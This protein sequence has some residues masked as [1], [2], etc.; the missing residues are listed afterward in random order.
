MMN[1]AHHYSLPY[2]CAI[3]CSYCKGRIEARQRRLI[4]ASGID[5]LVWKMRLGMNVLSH[6]DVDLVGL[7][8]WQWVCRRQCRRPE[9]FQDNSLRSK[10]QNKGQS[11][12]LLHSSQ[13]LMCCVHGLAQQ[14]TES[15]A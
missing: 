3:C 5:G 6:R 11:T 12:L 4:W 15:Q 14:K 2:H 8:E 7:R 1:K 9:V 10:Q 13:D